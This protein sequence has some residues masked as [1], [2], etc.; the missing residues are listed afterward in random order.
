MRGVKR[1]DTWDHSKWISGQQ[2][3]MY[4]DVWCTTFVYKIGLTKVFFKSGVLAELEERQ[5]HLYTREIG[6]LVIV[7]AAYA[8]SG[9]ESSFANNDEEIRELCNRAFAISSQVLIERSMV[10]IQWKA[11]TYDGGLS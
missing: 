6:Y 10:W 5:N 1:L 9:L 4:Q 3:G 8:L 11:E 7:R 2:E